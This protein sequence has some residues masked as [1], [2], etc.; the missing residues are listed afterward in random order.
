MQRNK[1]R[2][3]QRVHFAGGSGHDLVGI[4]DYP[5]QDSIG[6]ALYAPCFTCGKD[7]KAAARICRVLA[8]YGISVLRFDFTGLGGSQ[9]SFAESNFTTNR[10]DVLAAAEYLRDN[11]SPPQLLIG[12]S[13]GGA[14]VLSVA[15]EIESATG[16]V[17]LAAPSDT[18]HLAE[19][20]ANRDPRVYSEGMG[21]VSIGGRPFPIT[22]QL[23]EDLKAQSIESAVK[24]CE[25]PLLILHSPIDKTLR[26]EHAEKIFHW[27]AGPKSLVTLDGA[28]HLLVDHPGD[29]PF[30]SGLIAHW[31][32]RYAFDFDPWAK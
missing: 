26:F 6:S 7:I 18:V 17:T 28:D 13:L 4:L 22:T 14:A 9:G 10:L 15:N 25:H 31:A 11:V 27:A 1:Q 16:I 24:A 2:R 20:L 12:H 19:H 29:V 32:A 8:E 5:E 21:T 3:T 23:I 30:V